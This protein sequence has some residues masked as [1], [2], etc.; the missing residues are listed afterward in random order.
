[1]T[2]SRPLRSE[3]FFKQVEVSVTQKR[4]F[5]RLISALNSKNTGLIAEIKSFLKSAN[6]EKVRFFRFLFFF[7][8]GLGCWCGMGIRVWEVFSTRARPSNCNFLCKLNC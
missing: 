8:L 1:M 6:R 5:K 7:V 4:V 2:D 3:S